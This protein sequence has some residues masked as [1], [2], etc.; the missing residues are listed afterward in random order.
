[1]WAALLAGEAA[2]QGRGAGLVAGQDL[3]G[4]PGI[5]NMAPVAAA[6]DAEAGFFDALAA[7][8]GGAAARPRIIAHLELGEG[9]K[10]PPPMVPPPRPP[11]LWPGTRAPP[12]IRAVFP[13][14]PPMAPRPHWQVRHG[15]LM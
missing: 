8:A 14:P 12:L 6:P 13:R 10:P 2:A 9:F 4:I 15:H 3:D 7:P 11:P 1:M 5:G